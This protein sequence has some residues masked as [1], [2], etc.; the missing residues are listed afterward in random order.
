MDHGF[1]CGVLGVAALAMFPGCTDDTSGGATPV[2][3]QWREVINQPFHVHEP[4]GTVAIRSLAVGSRGGDNFHNRGDVIVEYTDTDRIVVEM[5]KFTMTDDRELADTDFDSLSIWASSASLPDAPFD[6]DDEDDCIDPT[7]Q[8]AWQDGCRIA[9]FF[10]GLH[11]VDRAGADLRITLP[12]EFIYELEVV[13]EDNDVDPDYQN[14]GN[15]CVEGLPGSAEITLSNGTAWVILDESASEMPECPA[16]LRAECEAV[17]WESTMCPCSTAGYSFS[18]VRV[19]SAD[20]QANDGV[21]DIPSTGFWARYNLR[22]DGQ[23][24]PGD[25]SPGALCEA[26]VDDSVGA[27]APNPGVN[28]SQQP[29][30]NQG[31]INYP[32]QPA[33]SGAGFRIEMKSDQCSSVRAT[34]DPNEFVGKGMGG[35]QASAERGNLRIC[36]GCVRS[37]GCEA[38]LSER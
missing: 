7:G 19:T 3:D 27:V 21:V 30:S 18:R 29:N 25:G 10:N 37:L 28:L 33:P 20:G 17:G 38:L 8:R 5:R 15:V 32:G 4:D 31:S 12:R 16:D 23:N 1:F 2:R 26:V 34:E 36:A 9:V 14:R 13:T 24:T 11:Q 6:L 22:N 35:E